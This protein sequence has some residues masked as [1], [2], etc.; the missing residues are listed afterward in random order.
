MDHF[1][2]QNQNNVAFS[3]FRYEIDSIK[4]ATSTSLF[5]SPIRTDRFL[6]NIPNRRDYTFEINSNDEPVF[7]EGEYL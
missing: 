5:S 4:I 7:D 6:D 1:F 3:I 2:E